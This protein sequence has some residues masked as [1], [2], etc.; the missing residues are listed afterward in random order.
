MNAAD[1]YPRLRREHEMAGG[2]TRTTARTV[3]GAR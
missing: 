1:V 3:K 2:G